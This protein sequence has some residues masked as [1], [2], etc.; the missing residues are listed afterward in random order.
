MQYTYNRGGGTHALL[1]RLV[2]AGSR[3]LDVGCASG[4]LGEQ[5]SIQGCTVVGIEADPEAAAAARNT[6]S[7]RR[8]YEMDL[9][10]GASPLPAGPFDVVLCADVLEHLCDPTRALVRLW[11]LV[12]PTGFLI[13]SLPNVAHFTMRAQLLAGRFK[14]TERGILDRTHLHLYTYDSA[15]GLL[16]AAGFRL[17]SELAG[18]NRFGNALSF[19]PRPIRWLRGLL[20]Y[21][22]VLVAQPRL[23]TPLD[24]SQNRVV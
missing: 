11:P 19:G 23:V 14:Y 24:W 4:Y 8:V 12:A 6:G 20:A 21:N 7:Y 16:Q 2:P 22:I 13:A 18:S 9:N 17:L 15:R 10:D 5:L 1:L 3:V